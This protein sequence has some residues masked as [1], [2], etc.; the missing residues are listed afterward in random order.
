MYDKLCRIEQIRWVTFVYLDLARTVTQ[1]SSLVGSEHADYLI[2]ASLQ[3]TKHFAPSLLLP[4][5]SC[6]SHVQRPRPR[7]QIGSHI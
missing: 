6:N 4:T 3:G 7:E 2:Q 1:G 5:V